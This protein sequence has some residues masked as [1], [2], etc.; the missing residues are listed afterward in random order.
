MRASYAEF[1]KA[2]RKLSGP[3]RHP[4]PPRRIEAGGFVEPEPSM[5]TREIST[6]LHDILRIACRV[7]HPG[8]GRPVDAALVGIDA[9]KAELRDL[10]RALGDEPPPRLPARTVQADAFPEGRISGGSAIVE[11]R[12]RRPSRSGPVD[13][14]GPSFR[15]AR[16]SAGKRSAPCSRDLAEAHFAAA[17]RCIRPV[18]TAGA[19]S[20]PTLARPV[21][22]VSTCASD[23]PDP[24]ASRPARHPGA[25]RSDPPEANV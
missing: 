1:C 12:H 15:L 7:R 16:T 25:A 14:A 2:L 20:R 24:A 6:R 13:R 19:G 22:P 8:L 3:C 21:P 18:E 5:N 11:H 17:I 10:I 4:R 9:V 23:A